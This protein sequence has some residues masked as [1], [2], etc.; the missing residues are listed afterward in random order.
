MKDKGKA[1][2]VCSSSGN[3]FTDYCSSSETPCK[4][5]PS[6]SA[7]GI[8]ALCLKDRL[9]K[10]VC[11]DCGEQRLSS[12]SCSDISS[13]Y[14]NSCSVDIGSVGRISF[15]IENEKDDAVPP[16][17]LHSHAH[18][19]SSS[20]R[21]SVATV[22]L[23]RSSSTSTSVEV[24]KGGFWKFGRLFRKKKEKDFEI[25][26]TNAGNDEKCEIWGVANKG[27][28]RSKS[29]CDYRSGLDDSGRPS[30]LSR[31]GGTSLKQG[32]DFKGFKK[33]SLF[34][35]DGSFC[36][37]EESGYIDLKLGSFS[38]RKPECASVKG[39]DYLESESGSRL[40]RD[41]DLSGLESRSFEC[42]RENGRFSNGSSCRITVN[43]SE[44][45]KG[46]KSFKV[47]K[48]IVKHHSSSPVWP[49][50][51]KNEHGEFKS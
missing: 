37:G 26:E 10:L 5:H 18:L 11:S 51:K 39:A 30:D 45:K 15:L 48:W 32:S 13:S 38:E 34:Y 36:G 41:S 21:K 17:H 25:S 35:Y 24:K 2:D 47:W 28:P 23:K 20:E 12:C 22:L 27:V 19:K 8:C 40:S 49:A 50:S 6:S 44:V 33:G 3:W 1:V 14:R 42:S 4:K 31:D 43:S 29:L 9:V 16:S 7:V 46:K